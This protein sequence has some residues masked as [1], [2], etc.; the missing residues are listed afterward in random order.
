MGMSVQRKNKVRGRERRRVERRQEEKYCFRPT[1]LQ[2]LRHSVGK[3]P[4]LRLMSVTILQ[5]ALETR[6]DH[7]AVRPW[8]PDRKPP[9]LLAWTQLCATMMP[10]DAAGSFSMFKL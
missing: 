2:L 9:F 8:L 1:W 7:A 10:A 6:R 4:Q 5:Q 3:W